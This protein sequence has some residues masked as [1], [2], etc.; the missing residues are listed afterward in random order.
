MYGNEDQ[1]THLVVIGEGDNASADTQD[2]AR[3]NFT[4]CPLVRME[5]CLHAL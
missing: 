1:R 3:V 5:R 4:M 2:H